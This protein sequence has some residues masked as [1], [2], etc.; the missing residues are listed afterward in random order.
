MGIK[1]MLLL[2]TA[3]ALCLNLSGKVGDKQSSDHNEIT[4]EV[5]AVLVTQN[6]N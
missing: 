6:F 2:P 4:T 5:E 3:L 1:C